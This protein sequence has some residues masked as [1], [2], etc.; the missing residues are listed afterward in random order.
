MADLCCAGAADIA[1]LE[2]QDGLNVAMD[3]PHAIRSQDRRVNDREGLLIDGLAP[4]I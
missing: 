4:G 1:R 2:N 3:N